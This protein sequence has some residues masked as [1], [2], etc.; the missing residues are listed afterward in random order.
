MFL[1][2]AHCVISVTHLHHVA[3]IAWWVEGTLFWKSSPAQAVG[4]PREAAFQY[5]PLL[6]ELESTHLLPLSLFQLESS[7]LWILC[8]TN[9]YLKSSLGLS[10]MGSKWGHS[11]QLHFFYILSHSACCKCYLLFNLFK[12][13]LLGA[14]SEDCL[15]GHLLERT[16]HQAEIQNISP[17]TTKSR[18][19]CVSFLLMGG[20][21][22]VNLLITFL[23]ILQHPS[24]HFTL[25]I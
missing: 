8:I 11:P 22:A 17:K 9:L 13:L 12:D 6:K 16:Y 21:I 20:N 25:K 24:C 4:L 10:A 23:R 7:R 5:Q 15:L 19:A 1:I 3:L 2:W 18:K 14:P